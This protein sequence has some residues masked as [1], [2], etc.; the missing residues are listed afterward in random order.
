[1]RHSK[2]EKMFTRTKT[3]LLVLFVLFALMLTACGSEYVDAF[4]PV[5]DELNS[6]AQEVNAQVAIFNNDNAAF[7]DP[8]WRSDMESALAAL[9]GAAVA[10]TNL[11][12]ADE[13]YKKLDNLIQQVAEAA[14]GVVNAYGDAFENDDINLV[15]DANQY[16]TEINRL[17]PQVNAEVTRLSD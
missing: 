4:N 17:L 11:P 9:D 12:E 2:G 6:A 13:D 1:V 8:Q 14:F 15:D 7:E 5:I 3:P 10:I 16:M